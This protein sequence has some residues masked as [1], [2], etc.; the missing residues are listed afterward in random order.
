MSGE[1]TANLPSVDFDDLLFRRRRFRSAKACYPCRRRKVKCDLNQP[2]G[3]CCSRGHP[4]LC[5]YRTTPAIS[6]EE[7]E[8]PK[9][10][11]RE[12]TVLPELAQGLYVDPIRPYSTRVHI[13]SDAL[14][15]IASL[16]E[17]I[18][19]QEQQGEGNAQTIFELLCLQD[20]S[21]TF[22]FLNLWEPG[23]GPEAVYSVLPDDDTI[24]RYV[25]GL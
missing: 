3:T 15:S 24:L 20:S 23:D 22:P 7:Q 9:N 6:V 2:C 18:R 10:T 14:P 25:V 13:G 11:T 4:H 1:S 12:R 21:L 8:I 17:K 16:S 19:N 5:E